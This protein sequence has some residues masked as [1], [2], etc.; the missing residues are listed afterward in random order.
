MDQNNNVIRTTNSKDHK[1]TI[2]VTNMEKNR[3]ESDGNII[4]LEEKK[5]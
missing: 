5:K 4:E 1:L 3:S 2:L